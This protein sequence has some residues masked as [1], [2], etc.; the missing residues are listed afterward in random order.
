MRWL[1]AAAALLLTGCGTLTTQDGR[2]RHPV[3]VA[4]VPNPIPHYEPHSKLGNAPSYTVN[5]RTYHV[6]ASARGYVRR[7]IASWY[8]TK[9]QGQHTSD[10]EIYNMY[11]MTAANKTLP[12]PTYVRVTNLRNGRNCIVRVNDRGPFMDNRLI[13]LSYA[14]AKKLDIVATGT[15]LVE[16]RA[17][18]PGEPAPPPTRLARTD[19][20]PAPTAVTAPARLAAA[21]P[22]PQPVGLYLQVGAFI[23]RSNAEQLRRRL[24]KDDLPPVVIQEGRDNKHATLYRVRVGPIPSV[25]AADQLARKLSALGLGRPSVVVD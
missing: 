3:D 1:A 24:A 14:A 13:D 18:T 19:A 21:D 10:G 23:S 9:F 17:I 4:D 8:G 5:G 7:G 22:P 25:A 11:A 6:L 15:G 12:L 16:V 20:V 2:P